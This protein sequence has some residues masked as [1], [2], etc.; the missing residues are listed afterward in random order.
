M[1]IIFAILILIMVVTS[2]VVFVIK[3]GK[4]L[5]TI[6]FTHWLLA[7]YLS[8][9]V[10]CAVVAPF[11][12]MEFPEKANAKE[13]SWVHLYGD[14]NKQELESID[15]DFLVDRK[16][17]EFKEPTLKISTNQNRPALIFVER[18]AAL[19]GKIEAFVYNTGLNVHGHFFKDKV[20]PIQMEMIDN[21]L[22]VTHSAHTTVK[23]TIV[24]KEFTIQQFSN[25][26][27]NNNLE[28]PEE[29]V[30]LRIP[31]NLKITGADVIYVGE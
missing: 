21:T 16:V 1:I 8:L 17:Y 18:T 24:E 26:Q 22:M 12:S 29:A 2:L 28:G 31:E 25:E 13:K 27:Q 15:P 14:L 10:I 5:V 30:Y 6:K 3:K 20:E 11:L 7:G 9:L 4:R 19:D 23:M